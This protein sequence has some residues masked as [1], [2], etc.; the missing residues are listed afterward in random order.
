MWEKDNDHYLII[1]FLSLL[2]SNISSYLGVSF[3]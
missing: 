2:V 1:L 3:D